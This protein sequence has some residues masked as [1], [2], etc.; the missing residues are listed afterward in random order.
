MCRGGDGTN[1]IT[2]SC[3]LGHLATLTFNLPV[4]VHCM[5]L[6]WFIFRP[7]LDQFLNE[8]LPWFLSASCIKL[9]RGRL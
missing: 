9:V 1:G 3:E 8:G 2:V 5:A 6:Q 7:T 4:S